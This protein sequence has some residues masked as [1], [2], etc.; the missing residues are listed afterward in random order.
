MTR[1]IS[2][3]IRT[4]GV[5]ALLA[6]LALSLAGGAAPAE[7]NTGKTPSQRAC[8]AGGYQWVAGQGCANKVCTTSDGGSYLHGEVREIEVTEH[9]AP[10]PP[11]SLVKCDGVTGQWTLAIKRPTP[12]V[13][14]HVLRQAT[15]LPVLQQAPPPGSTAGVAPLGGGVVSPR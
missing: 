6:V 5:A 11:G 9:D 10:L 13:S 8:E 4:L 3:F 2:Q 1:T 7:P 12:P 15:Q 14:G